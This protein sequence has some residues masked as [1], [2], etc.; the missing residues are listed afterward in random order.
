MSELE[1]FADDFKLVDDFQIE[2]LPLLSSIE[3]LNEAIHKLEETQEA[4]QKEII[5]ATYKGSKT[6]VLAHTIK[7]LEQEVREK[8]I[9]LQQVKE[10]FLQEDIVGSLETLTSAD[11]GG[12]IA[13]EAC[14]LMKKVNAI[15][16]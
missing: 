15:L 5:D 11:G 4:L 12:D 13:E 3:A 8:K 16:R 9:K 6:H 14:E 7:A 2:V 1:W 10:S